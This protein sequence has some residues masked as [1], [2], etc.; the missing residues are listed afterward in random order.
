M[1]IK[2]E[3]YAKTLEI[4]TR[5]VLESELDRLVG[6]AIQHAL[7]NP[8]CGILVTRKGPGTFTVELTDE[9][10]QGMIEEL[11]LARRQRPPR[12]GRV[13]TPGSDGF[14]QH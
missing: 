7:V 1:R 4:D 3:N 10:P 13:A 11:D 5:A 6:D 8:G 2:T 12:S 14:L 9:V